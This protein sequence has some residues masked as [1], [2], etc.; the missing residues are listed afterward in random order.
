MNVITKHY[1]NARVMINPKDKTDSLYPYYIYDYEVKDNIL[2][3][4]GKDVPYNNYLTLQD[5]LP[6]LLENYIIQDEFGNNL[7][8]YE[9]VDDWDFYGDG[10][11]I[12]VFYTTQHRYFR[13]DPI[14]FGSWVK[15]NYSEWEK[16]L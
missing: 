2:I 5:I 8:S 7:Y 4:H 1:L 14:R 16:T 13:D 3:L 9:Y 12:F 10:E 6:Y 15:G 11:D